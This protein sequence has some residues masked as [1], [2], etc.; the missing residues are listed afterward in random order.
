MHKSAYKILSVRRIFTC[1]Q[2]TFEHVGRNCYHPVEYSCHSSGEECS[3]DAQLGSIAAFGSQ[4][5]LNDLVTAEVGRTCR[6]ICNN[7]HNQHSLFICNKSF[8][9]HKL[10]IC[11]IIRTR[12]IKFYVFYTCD[13]LEWWYGRL[14]TSLPDSIWL[15]CALKSP[16][17]LSG[18]TQNSGP[19]IHILHFIS[20]TLMMMNSNVYIFTWQY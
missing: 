7:S 4:S 12:L 11:T 3:A 8:F 6:N 18:K 5:P 9:I 1:L 19:I 14:F 17:I 16:R 13:C 15:L 10:F 20:S 2:S